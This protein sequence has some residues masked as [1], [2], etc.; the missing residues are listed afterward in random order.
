V[1]D[2]YWRTRPFVERAAADYAAQEI[3]EL[4]QLLT[5]EAGQSGLQELEW[6][7]RKWRNDAF[8]PHLIARTRTTAFQKT[9]VMKY[10]DNLIAWGDSLFRRANREDVNEAIQLYLLAAK[11]LGPRPRRIPRSARRAEQT[12]RQLETKLDAFSNALVAF[13]SYLPASGP[14]LGVSRAPTGN[15]GR[16]YGRRDN[17]TMAPVGRAWRDLVMSP[18]LQNVAVVDGPYF[19]VPPN[20]KLLAKW[21]LVADRLFKLRHCRNIDGGALQM[22]LLSPPIDPAI[23]VRAKAM[24][25]DLDSVLNQL[26]APMPHYPFQIV[27]QKATELCGELRSLGAALL[28]AM[29]KRDGEALALLR[30]TQERT[31]LEAVQAIK[32]KQVAES[33]EARNGLQQSRDSAALRLAYY[34][35]LFAEYISPEEGASL[36]LGAGSLLLQVA[37]FGVSWGAAA[38]SLIPNIKGGFVTTLGGTYG[39]QNI[40]GAAQNASAAIGQLASMLSAL[41]GLVSTMGGYRRRAEE[42][43]HQAELAGKDLKGLE[44]QISAAEI[45]QE[46]AEAD[47]ENHKLQIRNNQELQAF[48]QD[49]FTNAELYDWMVTEISSLHFQTYQIAFELAKQSE[50][51]WAYEVGAAEPGIIKSGYWDTLKKGLLAGEHLHHDLKR[52]DVAYLNRNVR[53]YELTKHVSLRQLNP[54]ALLELRATGR[55]SVSLPETLFDMDTPGHYFR[56]IKTVALSIPCVTGP[57]ASVT[58]T[59]TLF[60]HGIRRDPTLPGGTFAP[61]V[62]DTDR[63]QSIVTS[64]AQ[65]DSGLLETNLRDER[66]LPFENAGV[67]SEWQLELPA[68]PGTDVPRQFDYETISDVILH[69]RYTA[70]DGGGQL[71]SAAAAYLNEQIAQATAAGSLQLLSVRHDFPTEWSQFQTSTPPTN[72]RFELKLALRPE[73]YPFWSHGHLKS[74]TRVDL[75]AR[76]SESPAPTSLDLFDRADKNDGNARKEPMTSSIPISGLLAWRFNGGTTGID[77]PASPIGDLVLCFDDRPFADLWIVIHW[78]S[79]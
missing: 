57:Y 27:L 71:R 35:R 56:R 73:H 60:K 58:C 1:P 32:E 37:Q 69:L 59:L 52:L 47:L 16:Y 50:Q 5:A 31:L 3:D 75:L 6:A 55:C 33:E 18:S 12:F 49:K 65:N 67:V 34:Q 68:R 66:Y 43:L 76:A 17:T 61:Q 29:E 53:E 48:M 24:G 78:G 19:C 23:L 42:W 39:G 74:V 44:H 25:L 26:Y 21:D 14:G 40:S 45:H 79:A 46:I 51:T 2:R 4:L 13:E 70:R 62:A 36:A 10:I 20:D 9:V 28:S 63:I 30:N 54:L 64:S 77:L 15:L 11:L 7:V 41:G 22:P 38:T 8:N 72:H